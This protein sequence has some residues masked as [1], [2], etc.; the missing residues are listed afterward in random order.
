MSF[1]DDDLR[2]ALVHRV[3]TLFALEVDPATVDPDEDFLAEDGIAFAGHDFDSLDL[4]EMVV[5]LGE[6]LSVDVF[7]PESAEELTSLARLAAFLR[8]SAPP[9]DLER[10]VKL[11]GRGA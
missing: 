3:A 6:E 9:E 5:T 8:A 10:F 11:W 4:A 1:D 2:A 7:A